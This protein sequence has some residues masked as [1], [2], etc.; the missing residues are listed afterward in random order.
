MGPQGETEGCGDGETDWADADLTGKPADR[1][2]SG[3]CVYF[4]NGSLGGRASSSNYD[5][6]NSSRIMDD[7]LFASKVMLA[8][9]AICN[10]MSAVALPN[11][12]PQVLPSAGGSPQSPPSGSL[13]L[14]GENKWNLL[15]EEPG[16]V[17]LFWSSMLYL[18]SCRILKHYIGV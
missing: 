15:C 14:H 10:V 2:V 5:S 17:K 9:V 8:L 4:A 13:L 16:G 12:T 1:W 18:R 11:P 3:D 7:S 6:T